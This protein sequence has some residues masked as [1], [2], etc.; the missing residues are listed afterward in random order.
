[1]ALTAMLWWL[2]AT[3]IL[4]GLAGGLL[5]VGG[6]FI[7]VPVQIWAFQAMGVPLDVAVKQA[8]GT[9]LLVVVPTALSGAW[10]HTRRDAVIWRASIIMGLAGAAGAALGAGIATHLTGQT[11]K[12]IFGS[13]IVAGAIRM[14]TSK[15]PQVKPQP[16]TSALKLVAWALPI[17]VLTGLIGIGGGVL[18]VPIMVLALGFSMHQAVGTSTAMMLFTATGGCVSFIAHGMGIEKLP[19]YSVGYV[20]LA[21]WGALA[22]TSVPMAQAG[23][24]LAHLLD[25]QRLKLVFI[26]VMLYMGLKM[27]GVFGWLGLPL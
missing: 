9:N 10:G 1:M 15:P 8:F 11:L 3:G 20:N 27:M 12:I 26:I 4:V 2:A 25:Q 18:M 24:K 7:M 19:P 21:A 5:G 13:A 6:C 17:G 22:L 23:L 14:L 16:E